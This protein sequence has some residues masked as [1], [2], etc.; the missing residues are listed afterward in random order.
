M[1]RQMSNKVYKYLYVNFCPI[2]M[3]RFLVIIL[4]RFNGIFY[5][6][7]RYIDK[8]IKIFVDIENKIVEVLP[9]LRRFS[10]ALTGSVEKGDD[11]VQSACLRAIEK[12][13]QWKEDTKFDSWI[14]RIAKNIFTDEWRTQKVKERAFDQIQQEIETNLDYAQLDSYVS[15]HEV[16]RAMQ[17]VSQDHKAI[18]M[19]ICV[20]GYTYK[21][22][23]E[24]L[25]IP[26]GTVASRVIRARASLFAEIGGL[27]KDRG[28]S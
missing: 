20:E 27:S 21:E 3:C 16:G 5:V 2:D 28:D 24:I 9:R 14:F 10:Y 13:S 19:L 17:K 4:F 11:L 15:L 22:V 26:V 8:W 18:L 23:S 25:D 7:G 1:I 6:L 12:S